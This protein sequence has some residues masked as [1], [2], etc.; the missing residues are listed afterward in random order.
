MAEQEQIRAVDNY[1]EIQTMSAEEAAKA[2]VV[3]HRINED[4][5]EKLFE[6]GFNSL[7]AIKR[8]EP[9]DLPKSKIVGWLC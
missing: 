9:D 2:W 3:Q 5:V 8:I 4:A 7:D 6:E 1:V